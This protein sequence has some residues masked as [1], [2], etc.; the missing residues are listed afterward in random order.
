MSHCNLAHRSYENYFHTIFSDV[1]LSF[2]LL[3]KMEKLIFLT[4]TNQSFFERGMECPQIKKE[5]SP[6]KSVVNFESFSQIFSNGK[7]DH[8]IH[9]LVQPEI[10]VGK[11]FIN[12][13]GITGSYQFKL[14][15]Y[16]ACSLEIMIV[17]IHSYTHLFLQHFLLTDAKDKRV[18]KAD[19]GSAISGRKP[20]F[21][22]RKRNNS[23][24]VVVSAKKETKRHA[25][26]N[27]EKRLL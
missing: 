26:E 3:I 12:I 9:W 21:F 2:V 8:A 22:W 4:S 14:C 17:F 15:K 11:H 19:K 23:L 18:N 10:L 7:T 25:I 1:W 16:C 20:V 24:H 5:R 6:A 27:N 13:V